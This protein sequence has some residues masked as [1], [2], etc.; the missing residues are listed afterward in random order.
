MLK[1]VSDS[2]RHGFISL[3]CV[4]IDRLYNHIHTFCPLCGNEVKSQPFSLEFDVIESATKAYLCPRCQIYFPYISLISY[5]QYFF[6]YS[7]GNVR[8][9]LDI[10][11]ITKES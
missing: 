2:E 10:I 9:V 7:R 3:D 5:N 4:Y 1:L 6:D 11:H 8:D